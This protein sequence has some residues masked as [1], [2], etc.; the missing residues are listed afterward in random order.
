MFFIFC[1]CTTPSFS[2]FSLF[3]ESKLRELEVKL[4]TNAN[5]QEKINILLVN[6]VGEIEKKVK[7]LETNLEQYLNPFIFH[8]THYLS[9]LFKK[10]T[11]KFCV[12]YKEIRKN[13]EFEVME[14]DAKVQLKYISTIAIMPRSNSTK[15]LT[16]G[17]TTETEER[18]TFGSEITRTE[19]TPVN[20][21]ST[22]I[23]LIIH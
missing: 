13:L 4:E 8:F 19:S 10:F 5:S 15:Y 12:N 6:K 11:S 20:V 21:E 17:G 18:N 1:S 16:P 23:V 14:L 9:L 7:Q 22:G 3:L 2:E